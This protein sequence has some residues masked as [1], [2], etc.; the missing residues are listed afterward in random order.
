MIEKRPRQY[1]AEISA[2]K[3]RAERAEALNAVP[4]KYREWVKRL[5][6]LTFESRGGR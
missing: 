2:M 4:E 5:V 1:A 3:T 6:V